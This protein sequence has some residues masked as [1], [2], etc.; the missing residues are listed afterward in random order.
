MLLIDYLFSYVLLFKSDLELDHSKPETHVGAHPTVGVDLEACGS[1]HVE[2]SNLFHQ[3]FQQRP[4]DWQTASVEK[5][6][7]SLGSGIGMSGY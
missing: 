6:F 7:R 2:K 3:E 5:S 4:K 1:C